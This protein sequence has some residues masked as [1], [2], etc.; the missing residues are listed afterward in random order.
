MHICATSWRERDLE[1]SLQLLVAQN[2]DIQ[3]GLVD[4]DILL[5]VDSRLQND[6]DLKKWRSSELGT[7]SGT[8]YVQG[9]WNVSTYLKTK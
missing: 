7:R 2:F 9:Q 6:R 4:Q 8:S 5:L 1:E 3:R